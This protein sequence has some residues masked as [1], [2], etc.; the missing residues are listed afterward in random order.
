LGKTFTQTSRCPAC[1]KKFEGP[2]QY[3]IYDGSRLMSIDPALG[4]RSG[5]EKSLAEFRAEKKQEVESFYINLQK[6][7]IEELTQKLEDQDFYFCFLREKGEV[8]SS[9]LFEKLPHP[10]YPL[11]LLQYLK[12]SKKLG[13]LSVDNIVALSNHPLKKIRDLRTLSESNAKPISH[14]KLLEPPLTN[15]A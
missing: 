2:Y 9:D 7:S 15:Q 1:Q 10:S 3:C 14:L 8:L 11:T 5:Q 4:L 13:L 6:T 12:I